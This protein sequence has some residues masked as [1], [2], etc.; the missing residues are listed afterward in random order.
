LISAEF[1]ATLALLYAASTAK[2][3]YV[4]F[5]SILAK[6]YPTKSSMKCFVRLMLM[7]MALL[8]SVI[9]VQP[10]DPK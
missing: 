8:T 9:F 2:T 10:I 7:A 5:S 6:K 4:T 1:N 3:R